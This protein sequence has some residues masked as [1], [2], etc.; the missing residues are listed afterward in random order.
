MMVK[1]ASITK[2]ENGSIVT[3]KGFS[4]IGTAIGLKKGEEGFR[5]NHL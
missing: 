4:A 1:V 3:P 2:L 5:G